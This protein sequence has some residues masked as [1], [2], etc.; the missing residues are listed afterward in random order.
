[1]APRLRAGGVTGRVDAEGGQT[2]GRAGTNVWAGRDEG[3]GE[4]LG[5]AAGAGGEAARA[6][7]GCVGA[8][9]APRQRTRSH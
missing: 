4:V 6:D 3:P 2:Q 1:M 5:G 9:A 7:A 8:A